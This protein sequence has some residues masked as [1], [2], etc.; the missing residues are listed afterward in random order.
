[1]AKWQSTE[2]GFANNNGSTIGVPLD[3]RSGL[4][5]LRNAM[6]NAY[7]TFIPTFHF[8]VKD[9]DVDAVG[10]HFWEG[11]ADTMA[12]QAQGP[13]L[14]SLEMN[15]PNAAAVV[16]K[17]AASGY[18]DLMRAEFGAGIFSD[19]NLV[20]QKISKAIAAFESMQPLQQ[21]SSKYDF[22]IQGKI[23]LADSEMRGMKLFMDPKQGNCASCHVMN[24]NSSKPE[25]NLFADYAYYALGIPRNKDIPSNANP[26][27]FD[28]GLCGPNRQKSALTSNVPANVTAD[29][30]C[31]TFRMV[32]LRN[33]AARQAFMH[34]GF[35]KELRQV[36]GFYSTRNSDPQRWYGPAGV[37]NALPVAYLPN[38]IHDKAPF[39]RPKSAGPLFAEAEIDEHP[40]ISSYIDRWI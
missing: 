38:I 2:T 30:F 20:Y 17:V 35:F 23:K 39:N 18:A 13:F 15:N 19:P 36:I 32:S 1:V 27:F 40:G 7:N 24:P 28:L 14:A 26:S 37:P 31:G 22:F 9:G 10:G 16:N 29:Q 6:P 4:F 12:Q 33:V 21:F 34:N 11:R 5:G 8:R 3:S 25:D